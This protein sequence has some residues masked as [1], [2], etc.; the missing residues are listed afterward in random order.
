[1]VLVDVLDSSFPPKV[2]RLSLLDRWESPPPRGDDVNWLELGWDALPRVGD[3]LI[4]DTMA[5]HDLIA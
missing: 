1:M 5:A 3:E 2:T 4:M